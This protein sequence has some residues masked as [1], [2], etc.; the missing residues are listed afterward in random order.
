M[1]ENRVAIGA[2]MLASVVALAAPLTAQAAGFGGGHGGGGGGGHFGGGGGGGHFGGG[3]GGMHFGGGGG[4][5]H[6]GGGGGGMH[7]GGGGL[8][9]GRFGGLHLGGGGLGGGRFGGLRLGGGGSRLGGGGNI[10]GLRLGHGPTGLGGRGNSFAGR[11]A[12]HGGR[13][14]GLGA[15]ALGTHGLGS[16][17]NGDRFGGD[18]F[19]HNRLGGDRFGGDRFGGDHFGHNRFGGDR[20]GRN[21]FGGGFGGWAGPVFWP[22][23]YDDIYGDGLWG[24]GYGGPFWDYGYGDIYSGLFSPFGYDDLAGYLPSLGGGGRGRRVTGSV[25]RTDNG[26]APLAGQL[27]Q[28]CG[29]DSKDIAGLPIDRI[30]QLIAPTGDQQA[31]LDD[32]ANA[33]ARAAETIK[34]ACPTGVAFTPPGRLVAMESRI[35]AMAQAVATVQ[36]PLERFYSSLSDE[37][38]ARVS[39]AGASQDQQNVRGPQSIAQGCSAA[40][41]A[42]QWPGAQIEKAVL[43]TASQQA[44]LDALKTAAARSADQLASSCPSELPTT[45]PARLA[46]IAKRLDVMLQAVRNV[47]AAL[48]DFYG[49]L[50]DEQKAQF[51]L[52]GQPRTAQRQG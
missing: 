8:G 35:D 16:H 9:G 13:Q 10:G 50:N 40:S 43:P 15:A 33:S 46:A 5:G 28:M 11:Q 7:L 51:N 25:A 44:K 21:R 26:A 32:L 45:P 19:G 47:S 18:R 6:F 30:Q 20:F 14:A 29:N 37:Q 52:I 36:A 4:G 34:A 39:A 49:S 22:Y 27:A 2:I 31:A 42:T 17:A 24:Y 12:L 38:K 23:A 48:A 41:A 1:K 3:G